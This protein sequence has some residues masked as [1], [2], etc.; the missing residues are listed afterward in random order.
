MNLAATAAFAGVLFA[1]VLLHVA[2]WRAAEKLGPKAKAAAAMTSALLCLPGA[3]FVLYYLHW[4]PEPP[5]LY[6]LRA[7]RFGEFFLALFGAAAGVWRSCLPQPLKP[8]PTAAGIF[9]LAIPFLKPV[10]G[11]HDLSTLS[12]RWQ[13]DTCLQSSPVTCGPACAASLLRHFG[14]RQA[15]ERELA[16]DAWTSNSGTEAWHL[17]RALRRRGCATRFIAPDGLPDPVHLPGILGTGRARAGHF[18]V[19][20]SITPDEIDFMDPLRGRARMSR[21]DFLRWIE[22]QPLFLSV[23]KTPPA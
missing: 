4:L 23:R 13:G 14:D 1:F 18:I 8:F 19:L 2:A 22:F 10:F 9:L 6:E 11:A 21:A 5:L 7:L 12:D 16:R 15:T 20:L 3:W 17:A